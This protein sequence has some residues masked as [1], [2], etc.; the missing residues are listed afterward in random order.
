MNHNLPVK[1]CV[2]CIMPEVKSVFELDSKGVCRICNAHQQRKE[3]DV[4]SA[5]SFES[6]TAAEKEAVFRKK[7]ARLKS[8]DSKYEC[9]V[10]VSGG[11]DSIMTLYIA[12]K[13][14]GLEPLAIFIDN[15]FALDE[16]YDNVRN[17]T[18]ILGV[19]A[20]MYKSSDIMKL[21]RI[22][23]LSGQ[24]IYYCRVCHAV[25]DLLINRI[26]S[27]YQIRLVLGGYTKGQQYIK[28]DELFRIYEE[29]DKN[30]LN[31]I[32]NYPEFDEY[33]EL[34]E[35]QTVYFRKYYPKI[36][37]MSPFKYIEWDEDEIISKL[38]TEL[39]FKL[40]GHSWPEKSTNCTFNYVAQLL[41]MNQ[42]GFAQHESELSDL[43]RN[44]EMTRQ[45]ALE[46]IQTPIETEDLT[47][48]LSKLKLTM[49][50]IGLIERES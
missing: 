50:D 42:F 47:M 39:K 34:F 4:D 22:L 13:V 41:A 44:R 32:G 16:M 6:R 45:R 43:V 37:H 2:R 27:Q 33:R 36:V 35:N 17:A 7:V 46:I 30:T 8:E 29:S 23:L 24:N 26:C 15:G 19:D 14:L 48:A 12:K 21:F 5:F 10:A 9:A 3:N 38:K 11:K 20:V 1:R 31:I 25:L 28:N 18:E 49:S 40:P